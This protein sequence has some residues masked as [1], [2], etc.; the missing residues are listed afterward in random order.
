MRT[1]SVTVFESLDLWDICA[2][3]ACSRAYCGSSLHGRIVAM[4]FALP[5]VNL[6]HSAFANAGIK[7]DAFAA[8][9]E[10]AGTPATV[11]VLEIADA[12]QRALSVEPGRLQ[13]TA[14]R[15]VSDYRQGFNAMVTNRRAA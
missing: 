10:D 4:A 8:T 1:P 3:I 6:R 15:L 7:Q 9:W 5:R 11:A 12:I 13:R 14:R 2:L